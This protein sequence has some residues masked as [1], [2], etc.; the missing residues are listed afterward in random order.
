[1][2]C[3]NHIGDISGLTLS[4][5]RI[6]NPLC[7]PSQQSCIEDLMAFLFQRK[8]VCFYCGR[9]SAQTRTPGVRRWQCTY[10]E[11]E[12]YLDEVPLFTFPPHH[13]HADMLPYRMARLQTLQSRMSSPMLAMQNHLLNRLCQPSRNLTTLCF[14]QPA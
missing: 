11:A 9:K 4:N 2:I 6:L 12:N 5:L 7:C 3:G 10:C 8:L 13:S 14:A 1:M